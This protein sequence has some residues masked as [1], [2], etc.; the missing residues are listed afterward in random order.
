MYGS[1]ITSSLNL[2][3]AADCFLQKPVLDM[4]YWRS[5]DTGH[6]TRQ[7]YPN[8][9]PNLPHSSFRGTPTWT[10]GRQ[11]CGRSV[12]QIIHVRCWSDNGSA[13]IWRNTV[14][15][16]NVLSQE[17]YRAI[18]LAKAV[19]GIH[20]SAAHLTGST[21][22]MADAGSRVWKEP[23]QRTWS[24]FSRSW[25]QRE[26]PQYWRKFYKAFSRNCR[27]QSPAKSSQARYQ[28]TWCHW[29]HWRN[30]M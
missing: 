4:Q 14:S 6:S 29:S 10:W 26:L 17:I 11:W 2:T 1:M 9:A 7:N 23:D 27:S 13:I 8:G 22:V 30:V 5:S 20:V 12:N 16:C 15:S 24:N 3:T 18:G 19:F 21:N 25:F 28:S